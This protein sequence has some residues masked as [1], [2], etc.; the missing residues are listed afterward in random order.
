MPVFERDDACVGKRKEAKQPISI[1][2]R[3]AAAMQEKAQAEKRVSE[4]DCNEKKKVQIRKMFR[5]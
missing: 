3:K 2:H 4:K 5:K 1:E